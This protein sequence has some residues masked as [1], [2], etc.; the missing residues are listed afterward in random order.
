M[1]RARV[2]IFVLLILIIGLGVG[3]YIISNL[4]KPPAAE[5]GQVPLVDIFV[6]SQNIP[7]GGPITMDVLTTISIPQDQV[8]TTM[9]TREEEFQL[10]SNMVSR[11]PL[12]QGVVLTEAM[13]INKNQAV[14]IAGPAWATL[15]PPGMTAIS[16]PASRLSLA[17]YGVSDGAHVNVNI[18]F[19]LVDVDPTFQSIT[20]NT[21]GMLQGPGQL[22]DHLPVISL[23]GGL[24]EETGPQGRLELDPSVQ[25][26]FYIMPSEAQRPRLTCQLLLQDVVV[27]KAGN[28][29]LNGGVVSQDPA[30][31]QQQAEEAPVKPDV[32][33][34]IV[35]PAD[36]ITLSYLT[37]SNVQFQLSI[38]NP[39]DTTRV[40]TDGMTLQ[41][42]LSQYNI[43][44]PA[45]LP[46]STQ[47]RIDILI[48][49]ILM[50]DIPV[51][52]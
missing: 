38:R 32:V 18:C 37:Y 3:A 48:A 12:D 17:S 16:I 29:P 11:F 20:P 25:Q 21:A 28:F 14:S 51:Q 49:P 15:V 9:Y 44:M 50:N 1:R 41:L 23:S 47:P 42:L 45:K 46:Y 34:L 36:S 43:P 8:I 52:Q 30:A 7:Q 39:N 13:I 35:S 33:T 40:L 6:T 5:T 24:A 31:Q 2:W 22:Q 10:T 4:V 19:L 27:L 26:P